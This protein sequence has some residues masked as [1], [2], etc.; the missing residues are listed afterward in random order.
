[1]SSNRVDRIG[2]EIHRALAE[3]LREDISDPRVSTM[4]SVVRTELSKDLMY[5]KAYISVYGTQ[6]EHE[7]TFSALI[8]ATPFIRHQLGSRLRIR[9]MPELKLVP[10]DSIAYSVRIGQLIDQI[11]TQRDS[12]PKEGEQ[13]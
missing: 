4:C 5:C 9:K 2:M 11:N 10:D 12:D 3:V 6:Q 1:M 13:G 8:K 7:E